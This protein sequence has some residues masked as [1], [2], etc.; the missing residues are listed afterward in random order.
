MSSAL[1]IDYVE[2]PATDLNAVQAFYE[3]VFDTTLETIGDPTG[4]MQMRA[5]P[6][7]LTHYG[8]GGAISHTPH[9]KP[10]AGGTVIYFNCHDC[11]VEEAR[12]AKSGG[13]VLRPKFSIG[14][15][16]FVS[17]C[18]DTEGNTFGLSSMK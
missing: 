4:E 18:Q 9:A 3:A 11:A 2:F 12:V 6:T 17:L 10:G 14:E 15:F 8:A 16:G 1:Q 13:Q 5:F 7:D